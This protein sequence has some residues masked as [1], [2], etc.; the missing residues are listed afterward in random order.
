[1]ALEQAAAYIQAVGGSLTDYLALFRQQAPDLLGRGEPTGYSGTVATTW[2]L[3]FTQLQSAPEARGLLRLLA[4]CAPEAVPLRAAAAAPARTHRTAGPQ[5]AE[6]LVPLLEDQVAADDAIAALRR[7]SFVRPA[8]DGAVSVHRLVQA[9]TADQIPAEFAGQWPQA[10]AALIEAAIPKDSRKPHTWPDF[11]A[12]L[13]HAEKA[14]ARGSSGME[15]IVSYLGNSGSY[16]AARNLQRTST[17]RTGAD[18]GPQAPGHPDRPA[19][20]RPLDGAG[21]GSGRSP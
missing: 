11:A 14:L 18:A 4:F 5:V 1:M 12:L 21:G 16:A 17:R 10:A 2:D 9:V 13:P 19:Q 6:A 8:G 7:Y 15:R 3:A 20:P